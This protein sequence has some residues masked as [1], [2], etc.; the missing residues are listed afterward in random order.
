MATRT[1]DNVEAMLANVEQTITNFIHERKI[2]QSGNIY[3]Y[4]Y[5]IYIYI[6][7]RYIILIN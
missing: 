6:H 3:I 7:T 2:Q 5:E 4:I 1:I